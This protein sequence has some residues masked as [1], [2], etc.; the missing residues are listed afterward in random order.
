MPRLLASV[1]GLG[2]GLLLVAGGQARAH[3]IPDRITIDTFVK[4]EGD[5]LHCWP[6]CP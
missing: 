3:D 6:G 4:P 5:R 2:F 1:L